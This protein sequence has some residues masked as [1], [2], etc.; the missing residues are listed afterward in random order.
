MAIVLSFI[1]TFAALGTFLLEFFD[2]YEIRRRTR[3]MHERSE[4]PVSKEREN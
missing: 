1:A 2:R 4:V 3:T